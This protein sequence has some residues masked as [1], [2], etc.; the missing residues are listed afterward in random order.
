M[1]KFK[2]K[3]RIFSL[4]QGRNLSRFK[5]EGL[6]FREFREYSFNEDAKKIDWKISA[7]INK[8]LVKEYDEERELRII[9]CIYATP[10]LYFGIDLLKSEYIQNLIEI[11]G[12]E[13]VKEDNKIQTVILKQEPMIFKPTKNI[14]THIAFTRKL[15][16]IDFFNV[17]KG[18]LK[19]L[20]RFKKSLL[21]L[22]GDFFEEI[23]LS[24]LKHETFV[25]IIRDIYEENPPFRGDITLLDPNSKQ[26]VNINFSE[27]DAKRIKKH[28]EEIDKKNYIH[29]KKLKI[30]F[31]KIYTN[32]NPIPKLIRLFK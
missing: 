16:E 6:D 20:N 8:P 4:L 7:K 9:L 30:P 1:I 5:G 31:T 14:K 13:A 28:I 19:I 18:D 17:Q 32:E 27:F 23:D 10:S 24:Y 15:G 3:K 12:I 11:L 21:V 22:I 29:F 2:T 25:I 26:D